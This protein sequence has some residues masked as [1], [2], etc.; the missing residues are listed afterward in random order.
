MNRQHVHL[1]PDIE[2]AMNVGSRRGKP[3]ILTIKAVAMH[4]AGYL[5]YKSENG[6]WLTEQVTSE[7]IKVEE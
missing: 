3:I 4:E 6:V 5:F 2:T 7:F 1:S